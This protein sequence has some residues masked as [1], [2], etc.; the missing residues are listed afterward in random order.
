MKFGYIADDLTGSNATAVL[1]SKMGLQTATVMN[2]ANIPQ[3]I[4][5]DAVGMD[6]DC[7]YMLHE[8]VE[9]RVKNA[10]AQLNNWGTELI[11]NRIDSTMRGKI[12][13]T[14]DL[15]LDAYG[16]D[17]VAILTPA[18]PDSGR[19]VIG[20]Y[21]LLHDELLENTSL[22]KDPMNP[23]T[24]SYVPHI[25]QSQSQNLVA[26]IGIHDIRLGIENLTKLFQEKIEK[27]FRILT[28]D[29]ITNEDIQIVVKV[30]AA[31]DY[32]V[33]PVDPG[34]L[35]FE[36]IREKCSNQQ[37]FK[38]YIYSIGSV[39][40]LTKKQL[41]YVLEK[42]KNSAFIYLDAEKLLDPNQ[43]DFI[44]K[45]AIND[46]IKQFNKKDV[47]IIS[48]S[49]TVH[50]N[51]DLQKV[52][53]EQNISQE[54]LAKT[55]TNTIAKVTTQLIL[56]EPSAVA[57]LISCGGDV[58]ASICDIA[59]ADAIK[60]ID[61]VDSLIAYGKLINGVLDQLPIVTKGG[62]IGDTFTL[63]QCLNFLKLKM[64]RGIM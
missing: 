14:T 51:I 45:N 19:K 38:K 57:G 23:I 62:L 11:A 37:Q 39:S 52:A 17:S 35:T 64:T 2:G 55:L 34:P 42:E 13:L 12:G 5:L 24:Q 43:R 29:A 9:R 26:H 20:G 27:G 56:N 33:F 46:A 8:I 1:L 4:D 36:Y 6:L 18:F 25:V 53:Y 32:K 16:K 61:E 54:I 15:L 63:H 60:L 41:A 59:G 49:H 10:I 30:M 21:L 40:D 28:V 22:N 44:I 3:T 50:E 7:R 31:V 58:T 48:T 47:F